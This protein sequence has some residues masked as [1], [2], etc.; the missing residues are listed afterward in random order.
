MNFENANRAQTAASLLLTSPG[1]PFLYYGEEIG[2][3]GSKPDENIRTPM[4]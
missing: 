4:Q 2:H 1:V 3:T